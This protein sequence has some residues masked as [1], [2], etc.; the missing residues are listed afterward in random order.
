M[1]ELSVRT[2]SILA[3]PIRSG[4]APL[5]ERDSL[6]PQDDR[7]RRLVGAKDWLRLPE[8]VRSR[9]SRKLMPGEAIVYRG[10]VVHCALSRAGWWLAQAARLVG[11]PLPNMAEA[12]GPSVVT[13]VEAPELGGQIWSRLY[14]RPGRFPQ[15]IHS[16]KRFRGPTGLEEYLGRGLVMRLVARV[17]DEQSIATLVFRSTGYAIRLLGRTIPLPARLSPGRCE[18]RHR[19]ETDRR[20]SF[21]LTLDHPW[22]GRLLHQVA[23]YEEARA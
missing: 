14:M 3:L 11:G 18:V 8:S 23:F 16:A 7:Y 10:E 1:T 21:T 19:A 17:E 12:T 20:F 9:F 13:V 6:G 4:S 15:S 5:N 2:A 22:A